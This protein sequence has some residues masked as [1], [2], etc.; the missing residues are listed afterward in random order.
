MR[1]IERHTGSAEE[2]KSISLP[3]VKGML[4]ETDEDTSSNPIAVARGFRSGFAS[5][6]I[7]RKDDAD[8]GV[9]ANVE[10]RTR[11]KTEGFGGDGSDLVDSDFRGHEDWSRRKELRRR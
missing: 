1:R 7:F 8:L 10:G 6:T 5:P 4:I 2:K 11:D 3:I 9:S